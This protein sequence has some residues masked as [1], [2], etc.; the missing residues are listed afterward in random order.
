VLRAHLVLQARKVPPERWDPE[1]SSWLVLVDRLAR[2]DPLAR[3]ARPERP[4]LRA[5]VLLVPWARLALLDPLVRK[6]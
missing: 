5:I 1:A 4:G 6:A 2:P 3:R